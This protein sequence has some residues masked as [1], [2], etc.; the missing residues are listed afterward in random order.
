VLI[1]NASAAIGFPTFSQCEYH[2]IFS[3]KHNVPGTHS[4]LVNSNVKNRPNITPHFPPTKPSNIGCFLSTKMKYF[5]NYLAKFTMNFRSNKKYFSRTIFIF[6]TFS[7]PIV[8]SSRFQLFF[9]KLSTCKSVCKFLQICANLCAN[10][11]ANLKPPVCS[12][13]P[14][15]AMLAGKLTL[16]SRNTKGHMTVSRP[17]QAILTGANLGW[18]KV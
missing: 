6:K 8:F 12:F 5:S 3:P 10:V 14:P 18:V 9:C 13:R 7:S 2:V 16:S 4:T 17:E 15:D 1:E 11:L